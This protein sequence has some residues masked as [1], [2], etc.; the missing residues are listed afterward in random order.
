MEKWVA[1]RMQRQRPLTGPSPL[2]LHAVVSEA[3]V[4]LEVGGPDVFARQLERLV[5]AAQADNLTIQ[6]LAATKDGYG[7]VASN[8]MVLH[9]AEPKIDPPLGYFDGPLGG[10]MVSDEGD[11]ATMINMFDDLRHM[12][13]TETD[14][15]E[16]LAAILDEHRRRGSRHA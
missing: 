1:A 9:F 16:M 5:D 13:L 3:A 8:F 6:V 14:S 10:Y 15:A 4:R 12:A 7:G 2:S 11:V